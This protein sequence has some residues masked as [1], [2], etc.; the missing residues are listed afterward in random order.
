MPSISPDRLRGHEGAFEIVEEAVAT[1][2]NHSDLHLAIAFTPTPFNT[3]QFPDVISL[4]DE[5]FTK[6][7]RPK[8]IP[9][10]FVELRAQPLMVLG[11]ARKN[12]FIRPGL[13]PIPYI[14]S[15]HSRGRLPSETPKCPTAMG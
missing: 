4:L 7:N 11:R 2:L 14:D 12:T 5:I 6:S 15:R 1:V 9:G 10:D 3:E 13:F 8:R